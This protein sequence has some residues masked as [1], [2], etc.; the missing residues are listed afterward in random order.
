MTY[1]AP[2]RG[3]GELHIA[4]AGHKEATMF[5]KMLV[6]GLLLPGVGGCFWSEDQGRDREQRGRHEEHRDHH[7]T[8]VVAPEHV[9]CVGCGHVLRGGVW[10]HAD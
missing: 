10:V 8:V 5:K 9:H 7:E 4:F 2:N 1:I 6:L 3:P